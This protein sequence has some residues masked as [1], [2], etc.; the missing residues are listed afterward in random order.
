MLASAGLLVLIPVYG[1]SRSLSNYSGQTRL[2]I[3]LVQFLE[4]FLLVVTFIAYRLLGGRGFHPVNWIREKLS[5]KNSFNRVLIVGVVLA[6]YISNQTA[7]S[8]LNTQINNCQSDLTQKKAQIDSDQASLDSLKRQLDYYS[9]IG[10]YASYNSQVDY[11]NI[12]ITQLRNEISQYN[13]EV[14]TCKSSVD[15][16]NKTP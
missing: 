13:T 8:E 1:L 11:Y 3:G 9:S 14:G 7:K 4:I 15:R 5:D 10:Y 6:F 12:L 2:D 16:Y